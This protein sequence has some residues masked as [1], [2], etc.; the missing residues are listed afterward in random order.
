MTDSN[1]PPPGYKVG[2]GKPPLHTRFK[3]GERRNPRGRPKQKKSFIE[4]F[5]RVIN[6]KVTVRAGE[7]AE[8]ITKGQAVLRA[9]VQEALKGNKSA[10]ANV[11]ELIN[12]LGMLTE[13]P[14][15]KRAYFMV[16][17][18][19]S[20]EEFEREADEMNRIAEEEARQRRERGD[21]F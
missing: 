21:D 3:K 14:E 2:Y 8:R 6:E 9:N 17:R 4:I 13:I 16:P 11:D 1:S 15:T 18:R 7:A 5:K 20:P 19:V 12:A 10:T